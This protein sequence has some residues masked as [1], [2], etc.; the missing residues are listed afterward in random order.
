MA[1]APVENP[2]YAV[3]VML[4]GTNA[5]ISASTG[6]KLAGPLAK[7]MLDAV[8]AIDPPAGSVPTTTQPGL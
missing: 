1:F 4:K 5:E 3:A 2:K 7:A 8:F 6:G